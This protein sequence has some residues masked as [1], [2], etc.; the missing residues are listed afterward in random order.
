MNMNNIYDQR[1]S[2]WVFQDKE[3]KLIIFIA[4]IV[5]I[6]QFIWFKQIYPYPNFLPDS[7]SYLEEAHRNQSINIWPIGYSKF[8]RLISCITNSDLFLVAVQFVILQASLFYFSFSIAY[9]FRTTKVVNRILFL[10]NTFNPL[11]IHISN[12]ISSDVLFTA[13]SLL[14]FSQ[15]LWIIKKPSLQLLII[16]SIIIV[17]AFSVRYNALYYPII[18]ICVIAISL[19]SRFK[20]MAGI[21]I[22]CLALV[23]FVANTIHRHKLITG[24]NT[25]SP[26]G[27]WQLASNA[28][29]AYSHVANA[30]R[31]VVPSKYA[32]LHQLVN[33]HMDSLQKI[34]KRPDVSLGFYYL[35]DE[36]APLRQYLSLTYQKDTTSSWI[37]KWVSMSPLYGEYGA[38]LIKQYPLQFTKHYLLSNAVNYYVPNAEF[39][40]LYNMESDTVQTMAEYWFGYKTNR[41]HSAIKDKRI[42]T[43]EHFPVL[44]ASINLFFVLSI[45]GIWV[46]GG[47]QKGEITFGK[48]LLLLIAVWTVNL[49][50][51]VLAS[52]IVLRYQV[53]PILITFPFVVMLTAYIVNRIRSADQQEKHYGTELAMKIKA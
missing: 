1:F 9:L 8:L 19:K 28:L 40:S 52:P 12:F 22:I 23:V 34:Q 11:L 18:S 32:N 36:K 41:I 50:F 51:S 35:W 53:F 46:L 20:K 5:L 7:Y 30:D 29:Y 42:Q 6:I 37:K 2:H 33:Q 4:T 44:L 38:I 49:I 43:M 27:G 24:I 17:L 47:M 13:L 25:F 15:L 39:L 31:K 26:F 16:H 45:L 48:G 3:N 21:G 10:C 14:W